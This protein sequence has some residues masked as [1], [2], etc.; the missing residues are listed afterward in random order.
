MK[1]IILFILLVV[2]ISCNNKPSLQK[3]MVE[4]SEKKDFVAL[5]FSSDVLNIPKEKL[6]Q[7]ENEALKSFK[8][9][10]VLGF[11]KNTTN[12]KEFEMEKNKLL[13]VMKDTTT[14]Q[15]MMKIGN[16]KQSTAIYILEN[17]EGV[18]EFILIGNKNDSGFGVVR[19]LGENMKADHLLTIMGLMNKANINSEQLKPFQDLLN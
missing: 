7:E 9:I 12:E 19:I 6:T 5:D 4:N 8:K 3:Y 18:E 16:N 17:K 13:E 11:K 1:K 14:Y 15:E 2:F 10:N